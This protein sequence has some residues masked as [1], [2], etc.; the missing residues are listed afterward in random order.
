MQINEDI[1][2]HGLEELLLSKCPPQTS[3]RTHVTTIK[4][5]IAYF[6]DTGKK[7]PKLPV[8]PQKTLFS[9]S[10]FGKEAGKCQKGAAKSYLGWRK[11]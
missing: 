9:K 10:N 11:H 2:V 3:H 1:H 8:E 5:S 6:T 4:L 7:S